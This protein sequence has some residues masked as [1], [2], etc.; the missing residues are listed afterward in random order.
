[1]KIAVGVTMPHISGTEYTKS[2]RDQRRRAKE[3]VQKMLA[4]DPRYRDINEEPE[5]VYFNSYLELPP[6]PSTP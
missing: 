5:F 3:I 4:E 1:M 6:R 2:T